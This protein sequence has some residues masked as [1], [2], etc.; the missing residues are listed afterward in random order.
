MPRMRPTMRSGWKGSSASDFS[1]TPMNLMGCAGHIADRQRR[2]AASVTV[3]LGQH[4]AGERQL[5]VERR[6]PSAPRPVRSWSRQQTGFPA[7]SA[8]SSATASPPSDSSSMCRR[9]AVSTIST[10]QP[11]LTA[12]RLASF[13]RR[14]TVA[15]FASSTLPSYRCAPDRLGN[16]L[17]LLARGGA[18][19]VHRHQHGPMP[20]LLQPVRQLARRGGLT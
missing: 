12:S 7:D 8:A 20:A 13:A 17:Q 18:V 11:E 5:F 14:S 4:H 9:P 6:R 1:P 15:V 16:D 10:S 2:A 19:D 3:H